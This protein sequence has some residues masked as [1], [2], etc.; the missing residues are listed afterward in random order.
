[1][2]QQEGG[3]KNFNRHNMP[4]GIIKGKIIDEDSGAPVEYATISVFRMRDSLLVS[5]AITAAD[6][7]F[8][9][10]TKAGRLFIKIEFISY[11]P[12]VIGKIMLKPSDPLVELGTINLKTTANNLAEVEVSAERSQ[13]E[14]G[15]DKKV[16]NVKKDLS[17][18][19]GTA[20][21]VLENIPSII[22]DTDGNISLRGSDN[23]RILID[24]KPSGLMGISPSKALEQIPANTIESVEVITNPSARYDAEGMAGIINIILKKDKKRGFNGLIN[25]TAAYPQRHNASINVNY[26]FEKINIF[27]SYGINY[28]ETPGHIIY[29]RETTIDDTAS[30]LDQNSEFTRG[31]WSHNIGLGLDYN[32]T[33]KT[34]ITLSGRYS[35]RTNHLTRTTDYLSSDYLHN[36]TNH[37]MRETIEDE[38]ST[39]MDFNLNFSNKFNKKKQRL[40]AD[41]RYSMGSNTGYTDI[42]E[43]YLLFP[44]KTSLI[45]RIND[46]QSQTNLIMQADYSHPITERGM[47]E[48]GY[49]TG[50]RTNDLDY[51]V[52]EYDDTAIKWNNLTDVSNNFIYDEAIHAGYILFGSKLKTFSYQLGVRAEQTNVTSRL[53]ES[54][55]TFKKNYV[56]FFPSVHLSQKLKKKNM[57][58]LSYS[59]RIK[60]PSYRNL[61][62][63]TSYSDPLNLWIGNPD[64]NPELTHS[65]ELTHIKYWEKASLSS[66]IYYKHTDSVMQ[67]IRTIDTNGIATTRPENLSSRDNFGIE[68]AASID[69]LKWWK[70]NGSFNYFRAIVD[71]GNLGPSYE[72]DSYSY[73]ARVNSQMKFWKKLTAQIM[74]NYRGPR[75]T[76]QGTRMEMYFMDVGLKMDIWERKGSLGLKVSDVFNSRRFQ[77]ETIG[78][79]FVINSEY[80]RQSQRIYLSFSYKINN[81]RPKKRKR[82]DHEY[83]DEDG[84]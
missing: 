19:G 33:P 77:T 69:I 10:E 46:A 61:N 75:I 8:E 76:V 49:K 24:G 84:M 57:I 63:F 45:Q 72:S 78:D 73:T 20:T 31:G 81:Y 36:Q 32:I 34:S 18:I 16:F 21:E 67:R 30:Y 15:L 58:Q 7:S 41:I 39:N 1:M 13:V 14:F 28:R 17:N 82:G 62:P 56:N 55:N 51:L 68:V 44:S 50:I 47:L 27:G 80:Y 43:D 42:A 54:N 66:S 60:R 4:D 35:P 5:G 64:L 74:F 38:T 12:K 6:G 70:L 37:F 11:E 83:S 65:L 71:G 79:N 9:I 29:S 26:G 48:L 40:T 52:E 2:A 59:R 53:V 3:E 22:V 23:V 25:V